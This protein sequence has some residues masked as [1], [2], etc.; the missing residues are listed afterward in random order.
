MSKKTVIQ[1]QNER[2]PDPI[3]EQRERDDQFIAHAMKQQ[4]LEQEREHYRDVLAKLEADKER[5]E[6]EVQEFLAKH[7]EA[8]AP[9]KPKKV[10]NRKVED[11]LSKTRRAAALAKVRTDRDASFGREEFFQVAQALILCGLPYE[12][13]EARQITRKARLGDGSMVSV[14]F[15]AGIEGAEM[16][17]GSDRSLL[18]FLFDKAVKSDS[19]IISWETATEFL[20]A[21]K[22]TQG[23]DNYRLLRQRFERIRGLV[24]GVKRTGPHS[25]GTEL[26]PI[27]RRSHLPTSI[28]VRADR[29]GQP[30]LP[31]GS[32]SAVIFGVELDAEFFEDLKRHH[33]PVPVTIIRATRNK[34][35]LQDLMIFL[36]WRCFAAQSVSLIP[37]ADLRLQFW[38][39]DKT[40]RRIKVR[41]AEAITALKVLWPQ[42]NA[43]ALKLGLQVGKPLRG[44]YLID[45]AVQTRRLNQ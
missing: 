23:G 42:L 45:Q 39:A 11:H 9:S 21:M 33:V 14:T 4:E 31:M 16:P 5:L 1:R 44:Q 20:D 35:Q 22:M 36:H 18:H 2:E 12:R 15:T 25:S 7:P 6:Q 34:S 27:I 40:E 37:W 26:L 3:L 32:Q 19:R 13:T 43:E 29:R 8:V 10:R 30:L 17:Y 24:I 38:Q 28:D 41:F